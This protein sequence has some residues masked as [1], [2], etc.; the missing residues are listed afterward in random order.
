MDAK[1][2]VEQ[3]FGGSK[4]MSVDKLYRLAKKRRIPA[5]HIDGRWYF[6][7]SAIRTWIEEESRQNTMP[8]V[9]KHYGRLRVVNE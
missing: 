6:S 3:V 1:E 4:F 5:M 7:L 9:L 2:T 8:E